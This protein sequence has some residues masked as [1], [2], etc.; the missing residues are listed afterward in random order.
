MVILTLG[1]LAP[2]CSANVPLI[3]LIF[4]LVDNGVMFTPLLVTW[5]NSGPA[6]PTIPVYLGGKF[7]VVLIFPPVANIPIC[8]PIACI[9]MWPPVACSPPMNLLIVFLIKFQ[10][11]VTTIG[12]ALIAPAALFALWVILSFASNCFVGVGV[13]LNLSVLA[14]AASV[15]GVALPCAIIL[16]VAG[17]V[18]AKTFALSVASWINGLAFPLADSTFSAGFVLI[19]VFKFPCASVIGW[20]ALSLAVSVFSLTACAL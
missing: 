20:L 9:P 2:Y 17:F 7:W 1:L 13:A 12:I 6:S 18:A 4:S 5:N 3:P 16:L 19:Y 8:P 14:V 11:V 15:N 10:V